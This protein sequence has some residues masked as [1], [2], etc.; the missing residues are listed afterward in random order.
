MQKIFVRYI[1]VVI[2]VLTITGC[3][4][5]V[6]SGDVNINPNK[7]ADAT[8]NTL[9]PAVE[10]AT[11]NS[12]FWVAYTTTLFSQQ[13]ASYASGPINDDQN[14]DVRMGIAYQTIYLNA[15]TNAKI[16]V[17][18]AAAQGSPY[19]S[20]IGKILLVLNL[21]LATDTWGNVPYAESFQAP[22]ILYPHYDKQETLYPLMQKML[23]EA[24]AETQQPNPA[25]L[26]PATDDLIYG[27]DMAQWRQ[28]ANMLKAR[29]SIHTTKKGATAAAT[30]AL[31]ALTGAY[32]PTSKDLQ[33]LYNDKNLNPWQ[34]NVSNRIQTGNFT[35]TP[36]KRF[37]DALNGTA[38]PGL[39]DP[40][41]GILI[42][43]KTSANYVGLPNGSSTTGNTTDLTVNTF[44]GKTGAPLLMASYAE[45]KF[46][47]AEARFLLNGGLRLNSSCV[48]SR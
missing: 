6:E 28:T 23:D 4:K 10:N 39:V 45:Q 8:L 15:L 29:L 36:S 9:L 26:K 14:R 11:A 33:L 1:A 47:E 43:K 2:A 41:I 20:A 40:R 22:A 12:H 42:D 18:K 44:F 37:V 19:Y 13:M 46:I 32:T 25:S 27:G 38:Y 5:F 35:I 48:K 31:A 16:V 34:I 7:P 30:A 3:K 24:I 17:S 21:Q